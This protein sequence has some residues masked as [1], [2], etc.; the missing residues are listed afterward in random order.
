MPLDLAAR[1]RHLTSLAFFTAA[2]MKCARQSCQILR[3][4][5]SRAWRDKCVT[6]HRECRVCTNSFNAGFHA[7]TAF[8]RRGT[9][10]FLFR[11]ASNLQVTGYS[12]RLCRASLE[13]TFR[14]GHRR[15]RNARI[16]HL[17]ARHIRRVKFAPT[18][19][20]AGYS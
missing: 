14:P 17:Q 13:I 7:R 11:R 20:T 4:A 15:T 19:V 5:H 8:F 2:R 18:P 16:T 1:P 12:I 10:L 6:Q 9:T 3:A